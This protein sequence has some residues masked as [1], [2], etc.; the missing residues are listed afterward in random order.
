MLGA[1]GVKSASQHGEHCATALRSGAQAQML[2]AP[3]VV[4]GVMLRKEQ[5]PPSC[6][7]PEL[8]DVFNWNQ[9]TSSTDASQR[10]SCGQSQD[11]EKSCRRSHGA[12]AARSESQSN[13]ASGVGA[14]CS[15]GLPGAPSTSQ[16]ERPTCS[17]PGHVGQLTMSLREKDRDRESGEFRGNGSCA[18]NQLGSYCHSGDCTDSQQEGLAQPVAMQQGEFAKNLRRRAEGPHL[19]EPKQKYEASGSESTCTRRRPP[20]ATDSPCATNPE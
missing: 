5:I 20:A 16:L 18:T 9:R 8:P 4:D 15:Y 14:S 1:A 3:A 2:L 17:Q 10:A 12:F 6:V 11:G 7:L 19:D 13:S